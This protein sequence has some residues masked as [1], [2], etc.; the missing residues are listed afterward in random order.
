ML[1]PPPL[2]RPWLNMNSGSTAF[3]ASKSMV[4]QLVCSAMIAELV[5]SHSLWPSRDLYPRI[6]PVTLAW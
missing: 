3:S 2:M 1:R 5:A 4:A 6:K